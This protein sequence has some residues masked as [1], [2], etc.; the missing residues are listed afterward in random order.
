MIPDQLRISLSYIV[1]FWNISGWEAA[2]GVRGKNPKRWFTKL[3]EIAS[4]CVRRTGI[5]AEVKETLGFDLTPI[6]IEAGAIWA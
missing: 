5:A 1:N 3:Q 2:I 6:F 4:M